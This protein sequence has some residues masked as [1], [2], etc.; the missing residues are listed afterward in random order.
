[1]AG[2][3]EAGEH[4][5]GEVP[6]AGGVLLDLLV[7]VF[8]MGIVIDQINRDGT[9]FQ[10]ATALGKLAIHKFANPGALIPTAA[11]MFIETPGAGREPVD[12][13]ELMQGY[14]EQS[15]VQPLREMVDLVLISRAY[16][17]NQKIITTADKQMEKTLEALG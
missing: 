14:L 1:M 4:V 8:V 16:E 2:G 5:R 15:N 17:A 12:E 13:P 6:G 3:A 9:V 10:G 7:A 11:G